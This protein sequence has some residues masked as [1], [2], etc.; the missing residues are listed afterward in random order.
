[1]GD[2]GTM[3]TIAE[4]VSS[5][6]GTGQT[7]RSSDQLAK[8]Q[9]KSY[10]QT[11]A[12][13]QPDPAQTSL[14]RN[15]MATIAP[16]QQGIAIGEPNPG[17]SAQ[18]PRDPQ[19]QMV[20]EF[21]QLKNISDPNMRAQMYQSLLANKQ[22]QAPAAPP[23]QG[24]LG[25][26]AGGT[27]YNGPPIPQPPIPGAPGG[28]SIPVA[29]GSPSVD[30]NGNPVTYIPSPGGSGGFIPVPGGAPTAP[31]TGA[32]SAGSPGT[33]GQIPGAPP[34]GWIMSPPM[35]PGGKGAPQPTDPR[36]DP[37][38]PWSE[39]PMGPH[40]EEGWYTPGGDTTMMT[41]VYRGPFGPDGRPLP[42][43][44]GP[45]IIEGGPP[46]NAN[47]GPMPP[48]GGSLGT[49]KPLPSIPPGLFGDPKPMPMPA[50]STP[51]ARTA[52]DG[53]NGVSAYDYGAKSGN[54]QASWDPKATMTAPT[55]APVKNAVMAKFQQ[56]Q[57][58][59]RAAAQAGLSAVGDAQRQLA[60]ARAQ[61]PRAQLQQKVQA[62]G[63]DAAQKAISQ[64]PVAA[65]AVA[66]R[67]AASTPPAG[68][69]S[70][71]GVAP[72]PQGMQPKPKQPLPGQA[73]GGVQAL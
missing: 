18:L 1:M 22:S 33:L 9:I 58:P 53:G 4:T 60:A 10:A 59:G 2:L 13:P 70:A 31:A 42:P 11:T 55:V 51:P 34:T 40:P 64:N 12:A 6:L 7:L 26:G 50:P 3:P 37:N 45:N 23:M 72:S 67:Q 43:G 69:T 29:Q 48:S 32:G 15:T 38:R 28:P 65:R 44:Q 20:S 52:A 30:A 24:Q 46:P 5:G 35:D 63:Q 17:G 68:S 41:D 27:G 8:P 66:Q 62:A 61:G 49:Y 21:P 16:Q 19:S 73:S 36:T 57:A 71:Q 56:A 54:V 47:P 25:T 14:R 39:S